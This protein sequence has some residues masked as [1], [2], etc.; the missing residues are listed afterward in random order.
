MGEERFVERKDMNSAGEI[1]KK[2]YRLTQHE[3]QL[4]QSH[5]FLLSLGLENREGIA[6]E[7]ALNRN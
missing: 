1:D 3:Y 4:V 2:S 6:H 7:A 5:S